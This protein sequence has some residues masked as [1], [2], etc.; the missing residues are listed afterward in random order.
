MTS[1]L[2]QLLLFVEFPGQLMYVTPFAG[3]CLHGYT[4]VTRRPG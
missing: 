3:L 1:L 2:A 4:W